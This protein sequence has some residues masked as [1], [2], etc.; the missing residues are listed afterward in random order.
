MA[1]EDLEGEKDV[2]SLPVPV[3]AIEVGIEGVI[4]RKFRNISMIGFFVGSEIKADS[5]I[6]GG[7]DVV[8]DKLE[9]M[10][11]GITPDVLIGKFYPSPLIFFEGKS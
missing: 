6:G 2:A 4:G 1:K 9:S 3:E 5:P 11:F 10:P 8:N 7:G